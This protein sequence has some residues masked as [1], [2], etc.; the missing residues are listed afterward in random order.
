MSVN[1]LN[2]FAQSWH[3]KLKQRNVKTNK[4][5][6]IQLSKK[7]V[8]ILQIMKN[9]L[10]IIFH[11]YQKFSTAVLSRSLKKK[12]KLCTL[13]YW[14][15]KIEPK[16]LLWLNTIKKYYYGLILFVSMLLLMPPI[17]D[18]EKIT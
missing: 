13:D 10:Y 5:L 11:W 14:I 15:K 1:E 8:R 18:W 9:L 16:V 4:T 3:V 12:I 2:L 7:H 6:T 17:K